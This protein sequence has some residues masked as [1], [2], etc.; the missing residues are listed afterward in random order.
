MLMQS[1]CY[2]PPSMKIIVDIVLKYTDPVSIILLG[3]FGRGEG[4]VI[5]ENNLVIPL[6]DYDLMLVTN[7]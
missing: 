6:K 1:R 5:I 4:S 7:E 3:S 2:L